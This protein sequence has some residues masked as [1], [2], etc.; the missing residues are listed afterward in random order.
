MLKEMWRE[1]L[2]EVGNAEGYQDNDETR[3]ARDTITGRAVDYYL[4]HTEQ[5]HNEGNWKLALVEVDTAE[6][7]LQTRGTKAWRT[8]IIETAQSHHVGK[9]QDYAEKRQ[10]EDCLQNMDSA[11]SY[12]RSEGLVQMKQMFVDHR[13]ALVIY[14]ACEP[15]IVRGDYLG[16]IEP[17]ERAYDLFQENPEINAGLY[18]MYRMQW[19]VQIRANEYHKALATLAKGISLSYNDELS[20]QALQKMSTEL[21]QKLEGVY[22]ELMRIARQ[23]GYIGHAYIFAR[24]INRFDDEAIGAELERLNEELVDASRARV[25]VLPFQNPYSAYGA[26]VGGVIAERLMGGLGDN[27]SLSH[28]VVFADSNEAMRLCQEYNNNRAQ[29]LQVTDAGNSG[30]PDYLVSGTVRK[31]QI[32]KLPVS[33]NNQTA[34]YKSGSH[35]EENPEWRTWY[36]KYQNYQRAQQAASNLTPLQQLF[37]TVVA[38]PGDEPARYI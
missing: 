10:W 23:N 30:R 12:E 7:F 26:N 19:E 4:A 11:L 5:L 31:F 8:K 37:V 35:S 28:T 17:L 18:K 29:L 9:A 21:S 25:A 34:Q 14:Q 13:D 3:T 36:G 22:S 1:A 24:L 32:K 33:R 6:S 38:S 15:Q 27:S 16:S 2:Q 20:D